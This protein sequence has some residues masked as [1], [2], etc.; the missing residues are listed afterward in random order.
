MKHNRP[1]TM[2]CSNPECKHFAYGYEDDVPCPQCKTGR[3]LGK[4]KK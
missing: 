3:L 1:L 4:A 2:L